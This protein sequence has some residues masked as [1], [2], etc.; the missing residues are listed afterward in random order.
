VPGQTWF[1]PRPAALLRPR[2][3][4]LHA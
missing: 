2:R 4:R 3:R 1:E